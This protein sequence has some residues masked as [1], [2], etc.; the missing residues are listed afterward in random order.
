MGRR[1]K[2]ELKVIQSSVSFHFYQH[3]FFNEHP[4]FKKDA[5]CR[6]AIDEQIK[7]IDPKFIPKEDE[8]EVP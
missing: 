4:E 8:E 2:P 3:Q 7:L 6:K 5:F 1:V